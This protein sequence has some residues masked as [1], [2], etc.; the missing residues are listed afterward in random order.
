[1]PVRQRQEAQALVQRI[2]RE[3]KVPVVMAHGMRGRHSTLAVDAGVTSH[4]LASALGH[5]SF[6]TTAQ[7]YARTEA[8]SGA[9]QRRALRLLAGGR[10]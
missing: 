7:S 2:C 4:A 8:V 6:K 5:E 3:A 1:M 10:R 9:K